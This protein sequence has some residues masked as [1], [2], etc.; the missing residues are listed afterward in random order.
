MDARSA[1]DDRDRF[2]FLDVRE[3]SEYE[4]GHISDSLHIP[5]MQLPNR[6]AELS[7]AK[8]LVCVCQVGQRSEMAARFL[9]EQ[10]YDAHN[11]EGGLNKWKAQGLSL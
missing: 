1:H 9:R 5:L 7:K 4:A 3:S 2:V 6:F 10:G 8:P 11:L